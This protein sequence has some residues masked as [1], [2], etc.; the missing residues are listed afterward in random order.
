MAF[1]PFI[2]LDSSFCFHH[3]LTRMPTSTVEDY[4]KAIHRF[5]GEK[6]ELAPMGRVAEALGITAGTATTMIKQLVRQGYADYVPR[7]GVLLTKSGHLAA[8]RVLRRHR[9]LELFLVEIMKYDWTEV[10]DE[11]E[12]LE[13]A[14]SDLLIDRIDAMLGRPV[15][16]PHGDLIPDADGVM[17][18]DDSK[19]LDDYENGRFK[20]TQV[21]RTAPEF[22]DWL[23]GVGLQ[24]GTT[25][26]LLGHDKMAD[27]F[28]IRVEG[29]AD[30]LRFG[31]KVVEDIWVIPS[32]P[33]HD[34]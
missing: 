28:R 16:D 22:L 17:R 11:A 32:E 30:E 7:K 25:F 31:Q 1:F 10:H 24:P 5:S 8:M 4:L 19:R 9:L 15:R 3:D 20:L 26:E 18:K 27:V 12:V 34:F 6:G 13:H 14:A 2:G 29:R 23:S 21:T 33:E